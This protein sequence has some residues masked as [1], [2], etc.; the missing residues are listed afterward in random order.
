MSFE[1]VILKNGEGRS[2]FIR[3]RFKEGVGAKAILGEINSPEL[4]SGPEGKQWNRN[5]VDGLKPKTK[6]TAPAID[7]NKLVGEKHVAKSVV[8]NEEIPSADSLLTEDEKAEIRQQAL[9]DVIAEK[10]KDAKKTLLEQEKARISGRTG[11]KTGDPRK[12]AIENVLI[13]LPEFGGK[14]GNYIQLNMPHGQKYHHGTT[15]PVQKHVGDMLREIMS[16]NWQ[17][18]AELEGK[19][20]NAYARK[21]NYTIV[22]GESTGAPPMV[23]AGGG[24]TV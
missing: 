7:L 13:D 11:S 14:Y 4:Y 1:K 8:V 12:D 15:Y 6:A 21:Q 16:R 9:D 17:H 19:R 18:Q 2:D 24:V 3:K 10:R 23:I 20:K 22:G 5:V